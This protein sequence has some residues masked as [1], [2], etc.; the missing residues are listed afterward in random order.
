RI[1]DCVVPRMEPCSCGRGL[2]LL[3]T[4]EGR[5]GDVFYLPNGDA[6]PGVALTNRVLK[7]CP[8]LKKTQVVQETVNDLRV[9]YVPGPG[10]DPSQLEVLRTGLRKFFPDQVR[11]TF[12][13]V[14]DIERERSGKT[15]FCISNVVPPAGP[16]L[17]AA[18]G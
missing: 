16:R 12:E 2:P 11:L 15:R 17:Q 18:K 10:F 14:A 8:G 3:G 7:V 4:I 9:R 5:T 1:N 13:K 6:V